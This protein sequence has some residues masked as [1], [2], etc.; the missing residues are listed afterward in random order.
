LHLTAFKV[1]PDVVRLVRYI[2]LRHLE[3]GHTSGIECPIN[4]MCI[5]FAQIYLTPPL[6]VSED[7]QSAL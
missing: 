5:L 1:A 6:R 7:L 4:A 2:L 3:T